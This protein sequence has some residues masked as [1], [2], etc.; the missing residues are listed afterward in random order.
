MRLY[1]S[2]GTLNQNKLSSTP[3]TT[4][5]GVS[6]S[7]QQQQQQRWNITK[8]KQAKNYY[9]GE[10]TKNPQDYKFSKFNVEQSWNPV[11]NYIY[12]PTVNSI[13]SNPA[14]KDAH[15]KLE[16]IMNSNRERGGSERRIVGGGNSFIDKDRDVTEIERDLFNKGRN[17]GDKATNRKLLGEF[18]NNEAPRI[19]DHAISENLADSAKAR[20]CTPLESYISTGRDMVSKGL[21]FFKCLKHN[22]L[23]P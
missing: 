6:P 10:D 11:S 3:S 16:R 8:I 14:D 23:I 20:Y 21:N 18:T 9:R 12:G 5:F 15:R 13:F 4:L 2:I 22:I 1:D 7:N 17:R 19:C